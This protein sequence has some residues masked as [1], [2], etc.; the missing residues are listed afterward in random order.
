[1]PAKSKPLLEPG[2]VYRTRD[3]RPWGANP[4]RLARR[5]VEAGEL[6]PLAHGLF[7]H[8]KRS[9]FGP[10]PPEDREVVRGFLG[11]DEFVLTGSPYWNAL[12]LGAQAV[13]PVVLVY[14]RERTGEFRLGSW[15]Y[16]LRRVRFPGSPDR[17]W[18]RSTCWS[19]TGWRESRGAGS[20][21][22]SSRR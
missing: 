11:S 13:F 15:R 2:K 17:E 4:T 18:T 12:G 10:V 1:M 16:R 14:N 5:L 20:K 9:G 22:G 3:L 19:T 21:P 8:P 7:Y 6:R